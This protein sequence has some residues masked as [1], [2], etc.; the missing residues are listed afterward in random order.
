VHAIDPVYVQSRQ[1]ALDKVRKGDVLGALI[2]PPDLTM[3]L[4]AAT[5]GEGQPPRVEVLFNA[6]D[7][8]KLR[9]VENTIKARVLDAKAALAK[10]FT[11]VA[12]DY[13]RLLSTGGSFSFLGQTF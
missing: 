7:P 10:K 11:Q 9:F 5:A 12:A 3:R 13:I 8:A 4:E 2:L 6:E 1:E